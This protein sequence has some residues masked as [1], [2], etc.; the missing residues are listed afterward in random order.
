MEARTPSWTPASLR[1]PSGVRLCLVGGWCAGRWHP[2][3]FSG[4]LE[5]ASADPAPLRPRAPRVGRR[6]WS[7]SPRRRR[8]GAAGLGTSAPPRSA[9]RTVVPAATSAT[10]RTTTGLSVWRPV[11]RADARTA[12]ATGV[13]G[14]LATAPTWAARSRRT[15]MGAIR[16]SIDVFGDGAMLGAARARRSAP[17]YRQMGLAIAWTIACGLRTPASQAASRTARIVVPST[18]A[19]GTLA[20]VSQ[21]AGR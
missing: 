17:A 4:W 10:R 19:C 18:S 16:R 11:R 20:S 9:A 2:Q 8:A 3:Q 21:P 6:V 12:K 1:R 13:V 15:K 14:S 5:P 7:C